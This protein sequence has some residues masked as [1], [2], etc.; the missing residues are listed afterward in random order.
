[1]LLKNLRHRVK[2]TA[3]A[4][5]IM[6]RYD[7]LLEPATTIKYPDTIRF[8]RKC[9]VQSGSYIYGS[10]RGEPVVFGEV[11]VVA[12]NC[13]VLGTGGL[14]VGDYTHLGPNVVITT[15]FGDSRSDPCTETPKVQYAAVGIGSG[16]WLGSGCVIMPGTVLGDRCIVAPNSVVF[17]RWPAGTKLSGNPARRIKH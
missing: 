16:C 8:G 11:C 13:M 2:L 5:R 7:V 6:A 17:G 14:T 1:M 9:T 15:Q 12:S 4:W 3:N 10:P